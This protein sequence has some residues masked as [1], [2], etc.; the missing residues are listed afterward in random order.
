MQ[1]NSYIFILLYL[2]FLIIAYFGANKI[3]H[4]LG[5]VCLMLGSAFFYFYGGWKNAIL[6]ILSV[7][8]NYTLVM[9]VEKAQ[10]TGVRKILLSINILINVGFLFY[11]K[12]FNFCLRNLNEIFSEEFT[13]KEIILPLGISFYTFQQLMYAI[14]MYRGNIEKANLLDYLTYILYFPKIL[15]GPLVEPG[16]LINQFNRDDL[17]RVNWD[18]LSYGLKIFSFG[19]FKKLVFA[20]TFATA[21]SWAY[22]N[23]D[24]ATS[25]DWFL[26]MLFYTFEIYFDFSGY[27]DMAIG[28]SKMLNISLPMNFDSPYKALSIRDFWKRWHISLTGY[29]TRY[30][31]IPLGG[32]K[33]GMVRTCVNTLIV[34][35]I[36]GIWHGAN[37]TFILWG[38]LHGILS[39]VGRI[40]ESHEKKMFFVVKWMVTFLAVNVLWLLFRSSTIVQWTSI[41][42][43]MFSFNDMG[44]SAGLINSFLLPEISYVFEILHMNILGVPASGISL[45]L[46]TVSAFAVCLVPE[47]N[48]KKLEKNSGLTM[49]MAAIAFI[50]SFLCLSSES[51]FVYFGF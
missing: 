16:E 21:V 31:Y 45:L 12:Y 44:I 29:F 41:L 33:M 5:K 25:M 3:S 9:L 11:Y 46:F 36:S 30:I 17:K 23:F 26:V 10:K 7:F 6:L 39:V 43:K 4:T 48:Y 49:V 2:P 42:M 34:F 51:V 15:M 14:N 24:A 32:S 8:I 27:S 47:N 18:N 28:V 20:D 19:L 35:L 13:I 37:W 22:T 40:L 1:F 50:W 38:V